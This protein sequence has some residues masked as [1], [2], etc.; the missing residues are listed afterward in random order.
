MKP[1]VNGREI[2]RPFAAPLW[3][4][5]PQHFQRDLNLH[6]VIRNAVTADH[7]RMRAP[8]AS[9][10]NKRATRTPFIERM[11]RIGCA[12]DFAPRSANHRETTKLRT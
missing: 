10:E 6:F 12:R 11:H 5:A 2:L 4:R 8:Q 1:L 3:G 9:P 7:M